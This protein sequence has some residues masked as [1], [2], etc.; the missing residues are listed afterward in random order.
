M[1]NFSSATDHSQFIDEV[2]QIDEHA[3]SEIIGRHSLVPEPILQFVISNPDLSAVLGIGAWWAVNRIEKFLE[4]TVDETLKKTGDAI[5]DSLSMKLRRVFGAYKNRQSDDE[6]PVLL[7]IVIPGDIDLILLDR[8]QNSEE[9]PKI[10]LQKLAAEIE[11]YSDLLQLA[12]EVTFVKS[13]VDDWK[14]QY[15][16]TRTGEVI[17]TL[18]CLELTVQRYQEQ[19]QN[20]QGGSEI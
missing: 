8:V 10:D 3:T 6:R 2:N 19:G 20:D 15:L 5:Y 18:E 13:E 4:Y 7:Q 12:Q 11:K 1:V 16:K 17:G 14:F 9:P